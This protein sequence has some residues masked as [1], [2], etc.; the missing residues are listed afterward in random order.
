[1][2]VLLIYVNSMMDNLI[3]L[4]VSYLSAYLKRAGHEVR[5][6]DTTFYR[7]RPETGDEIRERNL[8][9]RPT[10]L[11]D[12]GI[13]EKTDP[14]TDLKA[15]LEEYRPDLVASS[16]IEITF[17][18]GLELTR[19]AK[20]MGFTTLMG[21][22]HPTLCPEDV[23]S[24]P[25]V[26]IICVGEG[27]EAIVE[28]C[29]ALEAGADVTRI[30]N[31]WARKDGQV[32]RND[33]RP[34]TNLDDLPF[35]DWS[36]YDPKRFF[37][38]MGGKVYRMG[39]IEFNRGCPY[40]CHFCGAAALNRLAKTTGA[41]RSWYRQ[42]SISNVL[43]EIEFKMSSYKLDYWYFVAESF[44]TMSERRFAE[45][46]EG[47]KS[48]GVPF[49][50]E[51]RPESVKEDR[52]ARIEKLG[53][54]GI[55][56][57]VEHGDDAFRRSQLNRFVDNP[58]IVRA[59]DVIGNHPGIRASAN[60]IIGFPE[61]TRE[62]VFAT[63]HLCR[64]LK[65]RPVVNIFSPYRGTYLH[66]LCVEKGYVDPDALAGDYRGDISLRHPNFTDDQLLGLQR[67][68]LLYTYLPED[69]WPEIEKAEEF[70]EEGNAAFARLREEFLQRFAS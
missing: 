10:K 43:E 26:D 28:L 25:E 66:N 42:R 36:I 33:V 65:C 44:L 38:P 60:V 37:K 58:T 61:E 2:K 47:Y 23:M 51:C 3:P 4:G 68:F 69:R 48:V 62:Q 20:E 5:L 7:T 29:N 8:Q 53:C 34:L 18:L 31:I 59:F 52:I 21:G 46:E 11:S 6:F 64:Q 14:V 32:I 49:W 57:G 9:V 40:D 41:G 27:E 56:I 67:T 17:R 30:P 22:I 24:C 19:A 1:M 54:E 35:Q 70:T 63:I 45:F 16:V 39:P 12:V 15:V 55:S 50:I 13:I